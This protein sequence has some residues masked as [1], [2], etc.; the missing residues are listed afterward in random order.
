[1]GCTVHIAVC[2]GF[3]RVISIEIDP[4]HHERAKQLFSQNSKVELLLG[5]SALLLKDVLQKVETPA[6]F[7]LD[8]HESPLFGGTPILDELRIIREHPLKNHTI[9]IDDIRI[10]RHN[11]SWAKTSSVTEKKIIEAILA[12]NPDYVI[13]Y[14]DDE[15]ARE[16]V[17]VAKLNT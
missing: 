7:W 12:I 3:P 16:D 4:K 8:A 10:I 6:T 15:C 5:N 14:E 2:L 13:S 9:L 17:L 11:D 1:M